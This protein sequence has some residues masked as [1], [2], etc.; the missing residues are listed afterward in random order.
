MENTSDHRRSHLLQLPG[1]SWDGV[2]GLQK[3]KP[4]RPPTQLAKVSRGQLWS[5]PVSTGVI[6]LQLVLHTANPFCGGQVRT[7][8]L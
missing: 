8:V 6:V 5:S 7:S 3:G 4:R 1:G 2:P